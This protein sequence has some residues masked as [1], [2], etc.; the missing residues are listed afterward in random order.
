VE[1]SAV[2]DVVGAVSV[3]EGAVSVVLEGGEAEEDEG[4]DEEGRWPVRES[5]SV[6][7]RKRNSGRA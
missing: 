1:R 2:K 6:M 3:S 7:L 5:Q 4:E